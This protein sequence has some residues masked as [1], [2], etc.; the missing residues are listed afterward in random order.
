MELFFEFLNEQWILF[1]AL[2]VCLWL[3]MQHE[4]RKAGPQL[5]PQQVIN[6][7]NQDQATVIDLRDPADFKQGHIVDAINIPS[8]KLASRLDELEGHRDK[9]VVLVCKMGQHTGAA[10]KTLK[11]AGFADIARLQG[12]M[13]EWSNAQLPLV[14]DK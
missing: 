5:S 10:A 4:S 11:E 14:N 7:V 12:G 13:M 8:A 3:L 6:K 2:F 9:P 1:G